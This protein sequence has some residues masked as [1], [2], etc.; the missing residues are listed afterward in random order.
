MKIKFLIMTIAMIMMLSFPAMAIPLEGKVAALETKI[1]KLEWVDVP[2]VQNPL[3]KAKNSLRKARKEIRAK[4][5][6]SARKSYGDA[7]RLYRRAKNRKHSA[8][9]NQTKSWSWSGGK[10]TAVKGVNYGPSGKETW[11]NEDMSWEVSYMRY[12]GFSAKK[13]PY[14]VRKDGCRML[15]DYIMCAAGLGIRPKGTIV[16]SSLGRCIVVDTGGFASWNPYQLDI[17]VTW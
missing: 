10:L 11:Y 13:Y 6:K 5:I 8:L 16:E 12:L 9:N 17:A 15:G 1:E 2:K 4:S 14:W 3:R 7:V